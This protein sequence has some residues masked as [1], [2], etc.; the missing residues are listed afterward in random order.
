ML[1]F[2]VGVP[3]NNVLIVFEPHAIQIPLAYFS[4]LFIRQMFA[5]CGG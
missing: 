5:R 3:G 2:G 1:V 4:P